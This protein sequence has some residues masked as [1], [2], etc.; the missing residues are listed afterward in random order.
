MF[1]MW[2]ALSVGNIRFNN[3]IS[4]FYFV[5]LCSYLFVGYH[6]QCSIHMLS[7]WHFCDSFKVHNVCGADVK[8][9][10][11]SFI[12]CGSRDT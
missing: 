7:D 6:V 12:L 1:I 8:L 4:T 9:I 11:F 5:L 10:D 3:F 2:S